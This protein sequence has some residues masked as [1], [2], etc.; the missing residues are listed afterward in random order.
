MSRKVTIKVNGVVLEVAEDVHLELSDEKF[1][2]RQHY[3]RATYAEGCRG[4]LC[5]LSETH[6]SRKRNEERA[7][8]EGRD[9]EIRPG[10]RI[11]REAELLPII[12]WH[13]SER[14]AAR[15]IA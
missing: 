9:F 8:K 7:R 15:Q 12:T 3:S 6:R 13:L 4:P 11:D 10:R 1:A 2:A 14:A 5:R